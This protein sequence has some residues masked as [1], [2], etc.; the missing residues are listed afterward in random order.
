MKTAT[1]PSVRVD[2]EFRK[3]VEQVLGKDESLSQFVEAAVRAS[4]RQ[5]K[6]QHEFMARGLQ[7]LADARESGEYFDAGEVMRRLRMKLSAAKAQ[8]ASPAR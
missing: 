2:S 4:V 1:I 3:E 5:R 7:S 8:R 6:E